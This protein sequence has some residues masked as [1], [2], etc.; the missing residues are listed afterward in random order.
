MLLL[1]TINH[2]YTPETVYFDDIHDLYAG[3]SYS[4]LGFGILLF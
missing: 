1:L 4:L 2:E 3:Y